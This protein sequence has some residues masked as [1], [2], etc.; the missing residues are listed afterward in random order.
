M[1]DKAARA[2]IRRLL[3]GE[4]NGMPPTEDFG[5]WAD[6]V[7][8]LYRAHADG[9]GSV[10]RVFETLRRATPGLAELMASDPPPRTPPPPYPPLPQDARL[11]LGQE[12]E[13]ATAGVWL[14]EYIKFARQASPLTPRSFHEAAGLFAGGLAIARR[15]HVE[16]SVQANWIYPNLYLLFVGHSTLPRKSTALNVLKGLLKATGMQH[17]LLA[18][19]Q[20]PEALS[21]DLTTQI[22]AQYD[23]WPDE[24]KELWL[25]ERAIAAQRGW[26]LDEASHLLESFA[27]DYS[28]GLLPLVLDLYSSTEDGPSR[29]TVSRGRERVKR[30]YLNIFG[31]TTFSAMADHAKKRVHWNNGFFARFAVVGSDTS[32]EWKFWP[33]HTTF[34][35]NLV[36]RLQYIAFHLLPLPQA[37]IDE[38]T[39]GEGKDARYTRQVITQPLE[40]HAVTRTPQA[41]AQWERYTKATS[42]TMLQDD[43]VIPPIPPK[44]YASYGRLGTML[45]KVATILAAFDA[46]RLPVVIDAR[47]VYRAQLIVEGWRASL[48][49]VMGEMYKS[50]DNDVTEQVKQLIAAN[51]NTWTHR[52]DILRAIKGLKWSDLEPIINELS[53]AGEIERRPTTNERGPKSE[54]YCLI[55]P[56]NEI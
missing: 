32:G 31:A 5:R 6:V 54:E 40:S 53:G 50:D 55:V 9:V 19:R 47:H 38:S 56:K 4:A 7:L 43:T 10:R 44:F 52:R 48:H 26:L 3:D 14:D 25:L 18:E 45:I 16:V 42:L 2:C 34:P 35:N 20:S 27:R 23:S 15:L 8:E 21:L 1:S 33:D 36:N 12:A 28:S 51:G 11:S 29:N 37:Y 13:A 17:F 41:D 46:D 49:D 30:P 22:P 24:I 39:T